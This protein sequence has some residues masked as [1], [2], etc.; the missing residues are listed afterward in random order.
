MKNESAFDCFDNT[1]EK[2]TDSKALDS[3]LWELHVL[4]N[5]Y[6]PNVVDMMQKLKN[7]LLKTRQQF[8][9]IV[10]I[11]YDSEFTRLLKSGNDNFA[12]A[13]KNPGY[14]GKDLLMKKLF[15]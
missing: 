7:K 12:F 2:I 1:A 15:V 8:N 14:L 9:G 10:N 11:T 5:H 3:Y 6:D 4:L 13:I